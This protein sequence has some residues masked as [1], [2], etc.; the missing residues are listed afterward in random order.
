MRPSLVP[1]GVTPGTCYETIEP[2]MQGGSL[3][4]VT[5]GV[6]YSYRVRSI[7]VWGNEG[8][9]SEVVSATPLDD[10]QS[11]LP[12]YRIELAPEA[13]Q[14]LQSD[15]Y[16]DA[17]VDGTLNHSGVSHPEVGVR[18]RGNVT[19]NN[20]KK[21]WKV[22][23]PGTTRFHGIPQW[24]IWRTI[25]G[26]ASTKSLMRSWSAPQS[27]PFTVSSKWTSQV[28]PSA[29]AVFPRAA[30]MPPWAAQECERLHGI[31]LSIV[32]SWPRIAASTA[33]LSPASPPPIT[34]IF[35]LLSAGSICKVTSF[36][37]RAFTEH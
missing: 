13:L 29:I 8:V 18:F 31:R 10:Q 20:N 23:F 16:A 19:R 33:A 26:I 9:P 32:T 21:S 5:D 25:Q 12:V 24:S 3:Y 28:S 34:S 30:C 7:D 27:E 6:N 35:F 17:Y 11:L 4:L 15:P 37:A 1:L 14:L 22:N 2:S 36:A